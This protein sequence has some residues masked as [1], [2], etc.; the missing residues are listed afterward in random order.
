MVGTS[1]AL[2]SEFL[3]VKFAEESLTKEF[4]VLGEGSYEQTDY[5]E[6]LRVPVEIDGKQKIWTPNKD[7]VKNCRRVWGLDTKEWIG[8]RARVH[9][10]SVQGKDCL[11]VVPVEDQK[12]VEEKLG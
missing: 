1:K 8:K 6:K 12:V 4:V 10:I 11:N 2:E 5:G 9:I 7:S 3:T